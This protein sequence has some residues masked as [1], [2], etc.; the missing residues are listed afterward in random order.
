MAARL[1][2][3]IH[4]GRTFGLWEHPIWKKARFLSKE[5]SHPVV[6]S[7][8]SDASTRKK[9]YVNE[10]GRSFVDLRRVL[11]RGGGLL[12]NLLIRI[13]AIFLRTQSSIWDAILILGNPIQKFLAQF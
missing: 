11:V 3:R 13:D 4:A 8:V 5:T 9:E 12:E 6:N 1:C 2:D 10:R 7:V